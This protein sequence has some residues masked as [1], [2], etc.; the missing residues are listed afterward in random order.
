MSEKSIKITIDASAARAGAMQVNQALASI[1][2]GGQLGRLNGQL[3][4]SAGQFTRTGTAA[5]TMAGN[6]A[7]A[8]NNIGGSVSA[9]GRLGSA[10]GK[11][12]IALAGLGMAAGVFATMVM[13]FTNVADAASAME[14][15]LRIATGSQAGFTQGMADIVSIARATRSE[16][17]AVGN[18]YSKMVMNSRNLGI[19]QADASVATRTFAMA[20][21]VGG[22]S[23]DEANSSILQLSQAMSSGVLQGDEFKSLA[24]NSPVFMQILADSMGIPLGQLK[25]LGAEGKITGKAITDALTDPA[26]IAKIEE[27]FGKIPV[28]FAD[29]RTT[30]GNGITQ[31]ASALANGLNVNTSL[32]QLTASFNQWIDGV[33][34]RIQEFGAQLRESFATI[35]PIAAAIWAPI[36]A[37]IGLIVSNL[38]NITKAAIV[39]G[40]AFVTMKAAM[41]LGSAINAVSALYKQV[42]FLGIAMGATSG[43]SAGFAGAMGLAQRAIMGVNTALMANPF[44]ALATVIVGA[45]MAIYQFSDQIQIGTDGLGTLADFAAIVMEDIGAAFTAVAGVVSDVWNGITSAASSAFTTIGEIF[46]PLAAFLQPIISAVGTAFT[47][48]F[49]NIEFTFMGLVRFVANGIDLMV[50]AFMFLGKS[51]GAAFANAPRLVGAA[52]TSIANMVIGG[53][54]SMINKAVDGLNV[55]IGLAERIPGVGDIGTVGHVKLGRAAG[56][57]FGAAVANTMPSFERYTFASDH[58]AGMETRIDGRRDAINNEGRRTTPAGANDNTPAVAAMASPDGNGGDRAGRERARQIED[59]NKKYDEFLQKMQDELAFA[60]LLKHEAEE[61]RKIDEG[62]AILGARFGQAQ[63]AEIR[64]LVIATRAAEALGSIKQEVYEQGNRAIVNGMRVNGLS[65]EQQAIEDAIA[66]RRL[67]ALNTGLSIEHLQSETYLLEEQ[68]LRTILEQN[69]AYDAQQARLRELQNTG[70]D[71]IE[72]YGRRLDPRASAERDYR[73]RNEAINAAIRPSDVA[74]DAWQ[75]MVTRALEGSAKDYDDAMSAIANEFQQNVVNSIY[76]IGDALGGML[77]DVVNAIGRAVDAMN[78]ANQGDYSQSG[79]LGGIASL[80]GGTKDNR[81]PFGEA[82]DAGIGRFQT[83]MQEVFSK[84]L[85]SMANSFRGLKDSFNPLKEG[86]FIKGLGNALGGAMQGAQIGSAVAGVGKMIWSKFSTTGSSV[87]GALGSAFGPAG[88]LIG[89]TLGGLV[90]GLLKKSKYGT[91][92][93]EVDASTGQLKG[94]AIAGRGKEQQEA[95]KNL[96]N[97]VAGTINDIAAR[98]GAG[99]SGGGGITIGMYKDSYRVNTLGSTGKLKKKSKGTVDFGDNAEAAVAF[100]IDEMLKKGILTGISDFSKRA[101]QKLGQAG[102]GLAEGFEKIIDDLA[103]LK[104]PLRGGANAIKDGL[105]KMIEAMKSAGATASDLATVEEYRGLKLKAYMED[106]LSG[107]KDFQKNLTGEA[108]GYTKLSVLTRN[109]AEFETMKSAIMA[110]Q[111]V[112]Q[113]K[114]TNLGGAILGGAGD[115]YGSTAQFVAIRN[116]LNDTTGALIANTTAAIDDSTVVAIHQQTDAITGQIGITNDLLRQVLEQQALAPSN[117]TF[118]APR[119]VNGRIT[120]QY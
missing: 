76:Q 117:D 6:M 19:S 99:I 78:R 47:A 12:T 87:G 69:A 49:G 52:V 15:R 50:S 62:R 109:L 28:T 84:P 81:N 16:I 17:G 48:V 59:A 114:F 26:A 65:E 83:G 96:S 55:L 1:G 37:G 43:I 39:V 119:A 112:D 34:P 91:A 102:L 56:E 9:L 116:M 21:K 31:M 86:S 85:D 73:E 118:V 60:S 101:I 27:Q 88:S 67:D 45:A 94:M 10:L 35:A 72:D 44:V 5:R 100:A 3:T 103:I 113:D 110:G 30:V 68:R 105:D 120:Q 61:R 13:G 108:G 46:A 64:A 23:A 74:A 51:I 79:L 97:Q 32:A 57:S 40:S 33:L 90:G 111:T 36:S 93:F 22:A 58:V 107:L 92:G 89:S 115:I 77:G 42:Q 7:A 20:L 4:N 95:S 29:V 71:L 75:T 53:V 25:K 80:F 24:E 8:N 2:N 63:E 11:T 82:V 38:G 66:D 70:R 54:E 14:A 98:L 106:Q 104:D 18:L 41:A